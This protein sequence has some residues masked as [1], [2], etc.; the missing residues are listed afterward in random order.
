MDIDELSN[1]RF[2]EVGVDYRRIVHEHEIL[3]DILSTRLA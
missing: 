3:V 2:P 1:L